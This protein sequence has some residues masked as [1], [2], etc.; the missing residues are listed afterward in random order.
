MYQIVGQSTAIVAPSTLQLKHVSTERISRH[1]NLPDP[2][3]VL[4][5]PGDDLQRVGVTPGS[6]PLKSLAA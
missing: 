3:N 5:R 2:E 1:E 6:S 4:A